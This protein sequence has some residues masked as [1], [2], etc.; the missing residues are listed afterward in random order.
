M[1]FQLQDLVCSKCGNVKADNMALSCPCSGVYVNKLSAASY[2]QKLRTFAN[3]AEYHNV[4]F[5]FMRKHLYILGRTT[6][7]RHV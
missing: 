7:P 3:I 5:W 2:H 1:A 6:T 4:C